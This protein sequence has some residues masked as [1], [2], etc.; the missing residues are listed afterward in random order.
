[1]DSATTPTPSGTICKEEPK[2]KE[3]PPTFDDSDDDKRKEVAPRKN[4]KQN[5]KGNL[6]LDE[7]AQDMSAAAAAEHTGEGLP[8][9]LGNPHQEAEQQRTTAKAKAPTPR[10]DTIPPHQLPA[11]GSLYHSCS[12]I[13]PTGRL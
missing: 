1:V 10:P 9:E 13:T 4:F 12:K 3:E 2:D 5:L 8:N 6:E 11:V 7:Q